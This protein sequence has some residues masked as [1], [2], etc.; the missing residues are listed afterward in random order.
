MH[1]Q[2]LKEKLNQWNTAI[3]VKKIAKNRFLYNTHCKEFRGI[4]EKL[5]KYFEISIL[6][7]ELA[8]LI[9]VNGGK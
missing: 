6:C 4:L 1:N 7:F 8:M 9:A 5:F 3:S 2:A